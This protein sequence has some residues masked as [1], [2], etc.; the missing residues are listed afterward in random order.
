LK[1]ASKDSQILAHLSGLTRPEL[2]AL[3]FAKLKRRLLYLKEQNAFYRER[4]KVAGIDVESIRSIQE[5]RDRIPTMSKPDCLHDQAASPPFGLRVGVPRENVTLIN[6]TGGTS[7]QG[8]EVFGRTNADIAMQGH[9][10]YLPWYMAGLR[11]GDSALNCVPAG[12]LSTGGWGPTEGFRVA[13]VTAYPVGGVMTTDAKIDHMLRFRELHFIYGSPSYVH[14]LTSALKRRNI[15][16]KKHFPELKSL[17]VAAEAY[18]IELAQSIEAF[19]GA[20]LHEGY[21]STQAAGFCASTCEHGAIQ[22]NGRGVMHFF[23][24]HNV[25][26]IVDPETQEPVAP[27]DE[28][29]I[30][31]TNLDIVGSPVVR[32]R[33]GDK[34]R[35]IPH[36]SCACG[37]CWAGIEAGSVNRLDDMIKIRGN[38]MWPSAVDTVIFKNDG[39]LEYAGKVLTTVSGKTGVEVRVALRESFTKTADERADFLK[40]LASELKAVTNLNMDLSI[41]ERS[42]LPTYEYKS[43]RWKDER[44]DGF[45][46]GEIST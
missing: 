12:G 40:K 45:R 1:I 33:S 39:V 31:L 20:K 22:G 11:R 28:G 7:G 10:H 34:G 8:Q 14:T 5:F 27:G 15:D 6:L 41:V 38:N 44:A 24:W 18:P 16:P 46:K 30:I 19:W 37:R 23:E 42:A 25:I 2:L 13:G 21:G 43:R 26:E 36:G 29:E 3:Q 4:F 9:F 35:L 32:F 17:F